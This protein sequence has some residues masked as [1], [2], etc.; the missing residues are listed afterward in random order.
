MGVEL[1]LAR[2]AL[3]A[4]AAGGAIGSAD[5]PGLPLAESGRRGNRSPAGQEPQDGAAR[6]LGQGACESIEAFRFHG[7]GLHTTAD[8]AVVRAAAAI[9]TRLLAFAFPV[10]ILF[11]AFRADAA[12]EIV[13]IGRR[14]ETRD[15]FEAEADAVAWATALATGLRPGATL[16]RS[17][18][19]VADTLL[20]AAA[21]H[22]AA[23]RAG[24][25]AL[26]LTLLA[27][28]TGAALAVFVAVLADLLAVGSRLVPAQ[29]GDDGAEASSR[30]GA[31]GSTAR[32]AG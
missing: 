28:G 6:S 3:A 8:F 31:D 10:R 2:A 15:R 24:A 20:I 17:F 4:G 16:L 29:R 19:R 32:P 14:I 23:G 18:A 26:A 22:V 13:R 1:A 5:G 30:H 25:L 9:A 12:A 11:I 7:R 27:L 21:T